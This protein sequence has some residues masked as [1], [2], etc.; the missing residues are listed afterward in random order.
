M[1]F[2]T[3]NYATA[4]FAGQAVVDS[5]T[6]QAQIVALNGT[7]VVSGCAVT[8]S[9]GRTLAVASGTVAVGGTV[10]SVSAATVTVT[11]G[12]TSGDRRDIVTVSSSGTVSVT[13]GTPCS[14]TSWLPTSTGAPVKPAIPVT[15]VILAEVY[16]TGSASTL[17]ASCLVDK[18]VNVEFV[19]TAQKGVN[20]GVASLSSSGKLPTAQTAALTGNVTKAA[21]T[22]TTVVAEIPGTATFTTAGASRKN[23]HVPA[24]TLAACVSVSNVSSLSGH[25]TIDGYSVEAGD[26]VLLTAQTTA[27]QNGPWQVPTSGTTWT[28]PAEF[29]TGA[30]VKGRSCVV[31]YG[32]VYSLTNW[33]LV[34]TA[35]G[36]TIGTSAQTWKETS[37]YPQ[38][39]IPTGTA[40]IDTANLQDYCTAEWTAGRTPVVTQPGTFRLNASWTWKGSI[41]L[42][43]PTQT[44]KASTTFPEGTPLVTTPTGTT[45][46]HP[47]WTGNPIFDGNARATH[48]FFPR[49][50]TK[51]ARLGVFTF[52]NAVET[53]EVLGGA[54][55]GAKGIRIAPA[56]IY[57]GSTA[58][59]K[60]YASC[61]VN[62]SDGVI[63]SPYGKSRETGVWLTTDSSGDTELHTPHFSNPCLQ[64]IKVQGYP[65]RIY[66]PVAAA[67]ASVTHTGAS[68]T[69]TN[70]V[71][72]DSTIRK[73]HQGIRITGT[74]VQPTTF[75]GTV[76][77]LEEGGKAFKPVSATGAARNPTGSVS[78]VTLI[79]TGIN[80]QAKYATQIIGGVAQAGVNGHTSDAIT[81]G[82]TVGTGQCFI[83][84]F[85]AQ[86]S[87]QTAVTYYITNAIA[88]N[89]TGARW[90]GLSQLYVTNTL[91]ASKTATALPITTRHGKYTPTTTGFGTT[92][93]MNGIGSGGSGAS[94]TPTTTGK[95]TI[96]IYGTYTTKTAAA[97]VI[98][99]GRYGTGTAPSYGA[100]PTGTTFPQGA[101][102]NTKTGAATTTASFMVQATVTLTVGTKYWIDVQNKSSVTADKA[103]LSNIRVRVVET[104]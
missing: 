5:T 42:G 75:V 102:T 35:A 101:I 98:I 15:H 99:E 17:S 56:T 61:T 65:Q 32:T 97:N 7:Y 18:R 85:A 76:E 12:S 77:T 78:G 36:I 19:T 52:K 28:R 64:S 34:T 33:A 54:G 29:A 27:E 94:V 4:A 68:W 81:I 70:S 46:T 58:T 51:A 22:H 66:G 24:L 9:S 57:G 84:G 73:I 45:L 26:V 83:S 103:V 39:P 3:P 25:P 87:I 90:S 96:T 67:N 6:V 71:I 93:K 2:T 23:L 20:T 14:V 38:G 59:G 92:A 16:V 72:L 100:T 31:M 21:G 89:R 44:F 41:I 53:T 60:G 95:C 82:P 69:A 63:E 49:K 13:K 79:G 8:W 104:N 74:N 55:T 86:G 88:G 48:C 10:H 80:V 30:S 11:A 1:A 62:A 43:G 37:P 47:V 50:F 40:T 91:P